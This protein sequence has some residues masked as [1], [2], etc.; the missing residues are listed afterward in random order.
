MLNLERLRIFLTVVEE[1]TY[2]AAARRLHLSQ[3]AVSQQI[4]TLEEEL[5][6]R[7]FRRVG[8]RAVPTYAGQVLAEQARP[9]LEQARTA[10]ETLAAL[11]GLSLEPLRVAVLDPLG[12][13]GLAELWSRFRRGRS[14]AQLWGRRGTLALLEAQAA[15]LALGAVRPP[16]RA[17]EVRELARAPWTAAFWRGH[18][19]SRRKRA[20]PFE[21]LREHPLFVLE[22]LLPPQGEGAWEG[23]ASDLLCLRTWLAEARGV[24]LLPQPLA[25]LL[26]EEVR[27]VP[28]R[29]LREPCS[30]YAVRPRRGSPGPLA[31]AFWR[32]LGMANLR[33]P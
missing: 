4:R 19:L 7:L 9:L 24:A 8:R 25:P 28:V 15:D 26:G 3:P 6:V 33:L 12:A 31:E 21:R 17:W 11:R 16:G 27:T 1:G 23:I 32:F 30:L 18:P 5:G 13:W 10:Q 20:V 22:G 2:T 29:E 14:R